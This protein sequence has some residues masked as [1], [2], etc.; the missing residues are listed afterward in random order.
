MNLYL[1]D[2]STSTVLVRMLRAA[3]HD[4][5]LPRDVGNDGAKDPKHFSEAIQRGRV[6]LTQNYDDFK[7]LSDLVAHSAGHHPGV[8]AIR[9]D[10]DPRR[11]MSPGPLSPRS[12]G[13]S[14]PAFRSATGSTS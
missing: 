8:V 10:N 12:A 5:V 14:G 1:D 13:W 11:D 3:R 4:V 9:K 6:V 2:D 7:L